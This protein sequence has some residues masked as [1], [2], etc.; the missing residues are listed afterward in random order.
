M[1]KPG[2]PPTRTA[3]IVKLSTEV[4]ARHRGKIERRIVPMGYVL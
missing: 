3:F 2:E 4:H 1:Y